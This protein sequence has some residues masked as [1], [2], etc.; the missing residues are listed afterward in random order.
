VQPHGDLGGGASCTINVLF[1]PQAS[2]TRT[3]TLLIADNATG[4]PQTVALSGTGVTSSVVIAMAPGG[5]TTATTVSG[6]TAYYGLMISGA[7]GVTG[8]CSWDAC[9]RRC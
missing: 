9:R 6:G 1:T 7:P 3:A 5:S 2:G 8:R 4:S